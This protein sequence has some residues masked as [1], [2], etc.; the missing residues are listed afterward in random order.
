MEK[1]CLFCEGKEF[2]KL[3]KLHA[4]FYINTACVCVSEDK[5]FDNREDGIDYFRNQDYEWIF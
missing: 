2:L 3:K 1:K 4:R 5:E